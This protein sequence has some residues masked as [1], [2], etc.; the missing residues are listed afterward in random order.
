MLFS[1]KLIKLRKLHTMSQEDLAFK[2]NVSRQT[3]SRWESNTAMPDAYNLLELSKL[4]HVSIDYLL[5]D[6]YFSDDDLPKVKAIQ[7]DN[8][9]LIMFYFVI[10]EIIMVLIQFM[11]A[12]ILQS[13]FFTVLSFIPFV[14]AI[15]G[16]E[17]AY[18]RNR[19]HTN[20]HTKL[21]RLKF[22]KI[23]TWLGLYFPIRFCINMLMPLYPR[24]YSSLVL[25][26][27]IIVIY[28]VTSTLINLVIDKNNLNESI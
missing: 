6:D 16:F 28:I 27:I 14:G 26:I 4:F 5:N 8:L 17:Y 19:R 18:H 23:T 12:I 7:D 20:S 9:K 25:E 21:F 1:D 22:Y 13:P 24:P 11:S 10:L 15:G 2:L 3:I